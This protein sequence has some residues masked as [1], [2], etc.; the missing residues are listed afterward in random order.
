MLLVIRSNTPSRAEAIFADMIAGLKST[1][2]SAPIREGRPDA[3]ARARNS[4]VEIFAGGI[5]EQPRDVVADEGRREI[6]PGLEAVDHRRRGIEQ[7]GSRVAAVGRPHQDSTLLSS[8]SRV[9][10][11]KTSTISPLFQVSAVSQHFTRAA[12][13][14]AGRGH[15]DRAGMKGGRNGCLQWTDSVQKTS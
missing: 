13:I 14:S 6:A 7:P 2:I 8:R 12:A 4:I 3:R 10:S 15:Y 9:A 11:A 1:S 5:A